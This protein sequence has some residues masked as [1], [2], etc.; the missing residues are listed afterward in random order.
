MH[1][2]ARL[3]FFRRSYQGGGAPS[4]LLSSSAIRSIPDSQVLFSRSTSRAWTRIWP[5]MLFSI[6]GIV[7]RFKLN[8]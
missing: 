5:L 6:C 2:M 4:T 7:T 8:R 3:A 1:S